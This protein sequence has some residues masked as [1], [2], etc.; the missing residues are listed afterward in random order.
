MEESQGVLFTRLDSS[1][2]EDCVQALLKG[3]VHF[4]LCHANSTVNLHLPAEGFTSI[5]VGADT[6]LPVSLPGADGRPL[7]A[8]PGTREQPI[9]YLAYAG[10]SAIGR[11]VDHLLE[12]GADRPHLEPVF[13]SH[14]AAVLESMVRAGRG[15][16]WLPQSQ[17][18]EDLAK[19]AL[20]AAG[21]ERWHVPVEIRLFRANDSLPP[22]SQEFWNAAVAGQA[23]GA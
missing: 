8:L 14:L 20:V 17:I 5:A 4:M 21:D 12:H 6:V 10:T 7:H 3:H 15:L 18:R 23:D 1:H 2:A 16:A 9:P 11:A 22:K 19:G 13:V